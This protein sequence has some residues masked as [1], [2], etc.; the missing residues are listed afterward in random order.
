[1]KVIDALDYICSNEL[2]R[3]YGIFKTSGKFGL[4]FNDY[5]KV[6]SLSQYSERTL[7]RL[8]DSKNKVLDL[9][10]N[11]FVGREDNNPKYLNLASFI[12]RKKEADFSL[13]AHSFDSSYPVKK[14]LINPD[15]IYNF[16]KD[17]GYIINPEKSNGI[18]SK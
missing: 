8:D 11:V 15:L 9:N 7:W 1:M 13:F 17:S 10:T 16:I 18:F 12:L 6:I 4:Y 3:V 5:S 2:R 14:L